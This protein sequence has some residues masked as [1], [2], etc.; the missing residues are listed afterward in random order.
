MVQNSSNCQS[1]EFKLNYLS[2]FLQNQIAKAENKSIH[3]QSSK[4][5]VD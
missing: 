3:S 5:V 1:G 4:E 2:D